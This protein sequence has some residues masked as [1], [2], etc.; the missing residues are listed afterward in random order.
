MLKNDALCEG[1]SSSTFVTVWAGELNTRTGRV[2]YVN[3]GHN[4][5]VVRRGG[6]VQMLKSPPSLVLGAMPG[7]R[8]RVEELQLA[9]Q[10]AIYLY[11]DGI[12]E[13]PDA[14]GTLFGD[15]RL[16]QALA[17]CRDARDDLL[18]TVMDEVR[19][20]AAG[21]EQADDCTQLVLRYNGEGGATTPAC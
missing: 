21:T 8:Y 14:T 11:T 12:V 9:P 5:P 4:P 10:D 15:E 1:N 19:R 6:E 7:I 2:S 17:G 13:Q 16:L 3:A 20:H 18:S